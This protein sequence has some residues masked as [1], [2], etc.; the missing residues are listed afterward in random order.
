MKA[1]EING[2][3]YHSLYELGCNYMSRDKRGA[4]KDLELAKTY[5]LKARSLAEQAGDKDYQERIGKRLS[6]L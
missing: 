3:D 6:K 2:D 5:L 1:V 4:V